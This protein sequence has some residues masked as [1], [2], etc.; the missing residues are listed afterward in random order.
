[1]DALMADDPF[2]TDSRS[3]SVHPIQLVPSPLSL[4]STEFELFLWHLRSI[5]C[6]SILKDFSSFLIPLCDAIRKENKFLFLKLSTQYLFTIKRKQTTKK[7]QNNN[8]NNSN[9][10]N[11]L[12]KNINDMIKLLSDTDNTYI[13]TYLHVSYSLLAEVPWRLIH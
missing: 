3:L 6:R 13:H 8:N 7:P 2:C 12:A 9:N 1:M 11:K 5:G 4:Y 10:N